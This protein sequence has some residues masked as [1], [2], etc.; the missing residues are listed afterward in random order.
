MP[1]RVIMKFSLKRFAIAVLAAAGLTFGAFG[2]SACA[3]KAVVEEITGN[4]EITK[5]PA[6]TDGSLP[7]AHSGTEN[8]AYIAAV[9]DSQTKWHSYGYTTSNASIA[10]QITRTWKDYS[11]G[12]LITSDITY[13][14]MVKS[15]SQ[16]CTVEGADGAQVYFRSSGVPDSSTTHLTAAWDANPPTYYAESAFYKTYGLLQTELSSYIINDESVLESSEVTVNSDGTYTQS[17]VLDPK[18]STYYYQ[19]GMKTRGG[20]AAYPV[21]ESV[22]LSVTFDSSWRVLSLTARDVSQVNKGVVVKSVSDNTT[23]F[24]Y[25]D[26]GFDDAH[27]AYYDDYYRAYVGDDS[28]DVGGEVEEELVLDVTNVLSNGFAKILSGGDQFKVAVTLGNTRYVGYLFAGLDLEDILGTLNVRLSLGR[29]YANQSLYVEYANGELEAYYGNDFALSCNLA[30]TKLAIGQLEEFIKGFSGAL[31]GIVSLDSSEGGIGDD[32]VAALMDSLVLET[33][34]NKATLILDTDDLLGLGVGI[35]ATLDFGVSNNSITFRNCDI[36]EI[37]LGGEKLNLALNLKVSSAEIISRDDTTATADLAEYIADVHALLSSDLIRVSASL[38]GDKE[39]VNLSAIKGLKVD[40]DAYVDA[41]GITVGADA[42]VKYTYKGTHVS[43]KASIWYEYDSSASRYG[44]AYITL[45]ELNGSS[46]SLKV[47]CDIAD[48]IG[49]IS[50]ALTYS[51]A[52]FGGSKDSLVAVLN[53]AFSADLSSVVTELYADNSKIKL[54]LNVDSLLDMLSLDV[55]VKFGSCALV[56]ERGDAAANGGTLTA[57]LP[58]I[59]FGVKI[60]G[61]DGQLAAPDASDYLDLSYVLSDI[62]KFANAELYKAEISFDGAKATGLGIAE[63]AGLKAE[64]TAY[65]DARNITVGANAVVSYTY[66]NNTITVD[67]SVWYDNAS[68]NVIVKLNKLNDKATALS[69]YVKADELGSAV[70]GLVG[71]TGTSTDGLAIDLDGVIAGLLSAD[72]N[73]LLPELSNTANGLKVSVNADKLIEILGADLGI[74][75]GNIDLAYAHGDVP[76]LTAAAPA[77]GLNV[78]VVPESGTIELPDIENALNISDVLSDIE[79][80][81]NAELYKAEISFDGA[82]ATGLGIS[83][84]AGLKAELTAYLDARNITVGANAVVSYTYKTNTITVDISVWYDNA[85]GNVIVKLNKLNDKA[86]ALSMYVKAEELGSAVSGLVGATGTSTDGL[87]ID[88]DGVIAGLLSADFNELLPE[89]S[90]TANGLKVSVNADKLIKIL[91]ADLGIT[92]GNIDLAYAHGDVPE[93]TAAAPAFGLNVNVVPESGT[94]EL[95]DIENALN[96]SDVL[97]DIEKFAN[98]EL[99]KAEIS[100]DGAKATGF[101]IAELAGLKAELTAYL[102]AKNITVGANA[103]VSYTYKNNTIT[104]DISVWYDNASGNVIVKLNKLNDKATALS[105]YVKADELG[106]AVSGLVGATG[107]STDGLAIDLDGVIAGLLSADFNELL[108]ELSNTANGLKVSVNADKLIEILGADLGIT[109]GNI[110][111]AY[112]HGDVPELTAAA[113]ALGL[114]VNVVPE[115]G[116]IELPDIENALNISDVLSDIEKFANAEL[117]KAEISFDG[118]KATGLGIAEL[119][120]LKAELTAYLDAKN[121]TVGANAVVSYTYKS[122]TITVDISVWYDNASGNVIVKLNKLNDKATALSMYVKAEELG[123]AV[124]GLVGATGTS[125][126]GLA[127]DLDGVIAGLL[128]ADFNALLP[129]LSNTSNGLKVSVNADKL[130]EI[131]GADLGITL[132]NIDLAYAHGD[133]PELTAAAPAL[134]LNVN[135]VPES[136]TIELPD[137]ENALNISDV[138]SDIEKFANAEL[139]KAEIS[140]DGA[141]ATGLGIAEL[142]GLK[143][144]LTAYLDAK[145]ITVGANAVVSYTYKNNT[146][147]VDISVWYDNASGN[148]IVKLN[149]LNDKATALSMYVKAEELGSAVSG[150]V[151]ATGTS[152]DGLAIDLDGVIAGLLSADFNEL[153]PELSN[154]ANGLKVSVNADKLIEILGA[155]LGITLGNIDLA[156]AHGDVPELTAA[157]PALGLNVNVVPESG[158][159]ELPDIENALNISAVL[160]DIEKFANAELY[161]AEISFDG[162]KATGLGIAELA[163]LK[164]ELTAYLDAK[165]ITVGANAVVSYTYKNNTVYADFTVW[166]DY[167]DSRIGDVWL[168]LNSINGKAADISVRCDISQ[169]SQAI[170]TLMEAFSLEESSVIAT[171][172][173]KL[174]VTEVVGNILG[175]DFNRLLPDIRTFADGASLTVDADY[176]L[177]L[178]GVNIGVNLGQIDLAYD[179]NAHGLT[180]AA[181]S[182]GLNV[183]VD[184][185]TTGITQ[186]KPTDACELSDLVALINSTVNQVK[187]IIDEKLLSFSIDRGQTYI[188]VDGIK[189]ELYGE[190]EISWAKGQTYVALDLGLA[191]TETA[192]DETT[193]KFVYIGNPSSDRPTIRLVI[194]NV[195]IDV[196]PEDVELV[197]SGIDKIYSRVEGLLPANNTVT[198]TAPVMQSKE[199]V[200]G[201]DELMAVIFRALATGDWVEVLGDMSLTFDENSLLLSYLKDNTLAYEVTDNGEMKVDY[202]GKVLGFE[203][204]GSLNVSAGSANLISAIDNQLAGGEYDISSSRE[205]G[206]Q[207][208]TRLVYDFLFDA[209]SSVTIDNILGS[210][211]YTVKFELAG[212]NSGIA[213]LKDVYVLATMY[214]TGEQ[215]ERGKIAEVDLE[216]DVKGV[217]IK[218]NVIAERAGGETYFYINLSQVLNFKLPDLKV[219]ATQ[220]SLYDTLKVLISAVT[221][222]NVAGVIGTLLPEY[223]FATVDSFGSQSVKVDDATLSQLADIIDK[224]LNFNFS[225]AFTATRTGD[226]TTATVDFD[227]IA[228]QLGLSA[229]NLGSAE[230]VINHKNHTIKSSAKAD[231]LQPDG[232]YE[233]REWLYLLSEKTAR[234][235]YSSLD[236]DEYINIE[237]LPDLISDLVKFATDDNGEIYGSFTLSGSITADIVSMISIKIDISTLTFSFNEGQGIYFTLIGQLSGGLVSNN[238]IGITYEDGYLTLAKGLNSAAPEYKIMTFNYFIDHMFAT[239]GTSTLNYLLGV[240]NT[241]W[242]VVVGALG[243]LVKL[244]SGITKPEEIFLYAAKSEE[245]DEEISMY[246]F[247]EALRVIVDGQETAVIGDYG[248]IEQKLGIYDNYYGFSL[249]A[250][251]ITNDVLTELIAAIVRDDEV[252]I[253]GIKAYGAISSYVSFSLDLSYDE[254]LTPADSYKIGTELEH[255]KY[256]PSLY[257]A[258]LAVAEENGVTVDFDHYVKKPEEGY[259]ETFGCFSTNGLKTEY[260][261]ELYRHSLNIVKLDGTTENRDVRHGSTIHTYDNQSPVYTSD[262]YRLLYSYTNGG[263][264]ADKSFILNGDVTLYEIRRQAVKVYIHNGETTYVVNSFVGD[265]VPMSANGIDAIDGPYYEDGTPVQSGQTIPQGISELRLYGT[266]AKSKAEINFVEYTFDAATRSYIASG[267]AAGFNDKYSVNGETLVLENEID[268]YPVTAIADYA[269]ANTDDKPIKN[270]VVPSNITTVGAGA[271]LDNYGMTGAVF[272]ADRVTMLGDLKSKSM[273]FY[274]CSTVQTDTDKANEKTILNIYYNAV[275]NQNMDWTNFRIVEPSP[276][277]IYYMYVGNDPN[278]SEWVNYNKN[279]GG[280]LHQAGSWDYVEYEVNADA[281]TE[282]S[283]GELAAEYV[284]TGLIGERYS[285]AEDLK[286]YIADALSQYVNEMGENK[287]IVEVITGKGKDG[288]TLVSVNVSLNIPISVTMYSQ[289]D[290]T[291]NGTAV[292]ANSATHVNVVKLEDG[293]TLFSPEAAGYVFLGWAAMEDGSFVFVDRTTKYL[294][295]DYVYYAVWGTSKVGAQ[296]ASSVNYGGTALSGPS[297]SGIDGKW[298]DSSWNEVSGLS[299]LSPDNAIVYTRSIFT[300]T[301]KVDGNLITNL[302][303]SLSGYNGTTDNLSRSFTAYEGQTITAERSADQYSMTIRADGIEITTITLKKTWFV[304]YKFKESGASIVSI[305][306]DGELT[307][308]Y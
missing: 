18:L 163:G 205:E 79:K 119:A 287:Y 245:E 116:T 151:G 45:T 175:A 237:F 187:Q 196:Y 206:A 148:V 239:D 67:I 69:M 308:T 290:M 29:D 285:G 39:G 130:I 255:G 301:Y 171:D 16:T 273:P 68:G 123:S 214:M 72:F 248:T 133:V 164:A 202:S 65:L 264:V 184:T 4:T 118:A 154:T 167:D 134:G 80:F 11:D 53:G 99:Y 201:G 58:A 89:L 168:T 286:A 242:K 33:S 126:D 218:L 62:E 1:Q 291:Y 63:L 208:F 115:S 232:S 302:S 275:T 305:D 204:G 83:E 212:D 234:R 131:L 85:S 141:K 52:D 243:D 114:N 284:Q 178:L 95:P 244:D 138:L 40:L 251:L 9:L 254:G 150:L 263:E 93:L 74:T 268:G 71:A 91:G 299:A 303:D 120:G 283:V 189:A 235:D 15:G 92:L 6:P 173:G 300:V 193:I 87:A 179:C 165:N 78:N 228:M 211:T 166:Y 81:A 281:V 75:L 223:E 282:I 86:T 55:G 49:G 84:L 127:I 227:N 185:A 209:I 139:Y 257:R 42:A 101:G 162:A 195:G 13:S 229:G 180:L 210:D 174:D 203:L 238:T 98:A 113:P 140:F 177:T 160:S 183:D 157:A 70:S 253:S 22:N 153:L 135:V 107:T 296:F 260:S 112:A 94:I 76:E 143:A 256:A 142:A 197:K 17:F 44:K 125:T 276:A 207:G 73:E 36:T 129:E 136:G 109:L 82:K 34:E 169:L 47:G 14:S 106:S 267:K 30:E 128:S 270:V 200:S 35:R 199:S 219:M 121:I 304:H 249:N 172:F 250:G 158:T 2:V 149:K 110:D 198:T 66:K 231:V 279:G 182:L 292:Y 192:T 20:L 272:L 124:S 220:S 307:F 259:D 10:T 12:V 216:L 236:K 215:G 246:D 24:S 61:A 37:S 224:L 28:L 156:Y 240:N 152:T 161:K 297:G 8:L 122:S 159:I 186:Q 137:I 32:A 19:Y 274:G 64:L 226:V 213:E 194:N 278:T 96:I 146:I 5:T 21:F 102:D 269:F 38:D 288:S 265:Y 59:G 225:Q 294:G 111:L 60:S 252:G 261:K 77:L 51:G 293:I 188:S 88:L 222:T 247:V 262:G 271:F 41:D 90:N 190:G 105:M 191:L 230:A 277:I 266:F 258:A 31:E 117:Y 144:E 57:S 103:V 48:I 145:N 50:S 43:A 280:A 170:E 306:K 295:E 176:L 221:D 233:T 23:V 132:G 27:F 54:G 46:L 289:I 181:N 108:P 217:E 241:L 298:Y 3:K 155:D 100:F 147:T 26:D 104:V 56:Y 97:S 7:T 25:G